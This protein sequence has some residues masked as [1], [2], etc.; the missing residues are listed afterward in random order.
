MR[1]AGCLM[2]LALALVLLP[3]GQRCALAQLEPEEAVELGRETLSKGLLDRHPWYDEQTDDVKLIPIRQPVQEA[4]TNWNW[5][6]PDWNWEFGL[7][8]SS[9]S[10]NIF[11]LLVWVVV[12]V[13]VYFAM[14]YLIQLYERR[15]SEDASGDEESSAST[16]ADRV[17]AL[18]VAVK[19]N[20]GDLQS[21][22][23]RLAG[24]GRYGEAIVYLYSHLLVQLDRR[25]AIRLTKGKTN[26]QYLREA[27]ACHAGLQPMVERTMT[28][29]EDSYFGRHAL[30]A[31][32][33][34]ACWNEVQRLEIILKP[35][36]V[37]A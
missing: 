28:A 9:F 30:P 37:L 12:L 23:R 18:P 8:G 21:E 34:E 25:Q 17:E 31:D 33:F 10:V 2:M 20:V 15:E 22:A 3:G 13:L 29:F 36:E 27:T 11:T 26:R 5:D 19:R 7:F 14:R 16:D 35:Q 1:S 6:W 32:E 4:Q 24:E